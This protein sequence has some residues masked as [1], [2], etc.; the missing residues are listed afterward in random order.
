MTV[1]LGEGILTSL[2]LPGVMEITNAAIIL[3]QRVA[4]DLLTETASDAGVSPGVILEENT[5]DHLGILQTFETRITTPCVG[6]EPSHD[7]YRPDD[8][9]ALLTDLLECAVHHWGEDVLTPMASL[10]N[11][12]AS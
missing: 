9:D 6:G 1:P 10:L 11:G 12:F 8:G 2:R 3:C 5:S 4:L 7:C